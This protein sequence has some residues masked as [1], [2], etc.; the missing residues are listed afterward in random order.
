MEKESSNE[1]RKFKSEMSST[2]AGDDNDVI[3]SLPD[4]VLCHILSF[5]PTIVSKR[6]T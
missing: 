1:S 3:S 2:A 6:W 5:L 4:A